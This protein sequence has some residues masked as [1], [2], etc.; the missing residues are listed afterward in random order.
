MAVQVTLVVAVA[1]NGIIGAQGG[2]P[3]H[4]PA[5]LSHFKQV[6]LGKPVLMGRLT[7]DSIGRPLP[8]RRNLVLTS[9]PEWQ[10]E[11]AQRVSSLDQALALA[12]AG[13]A[14]ELMVIG[15]AA[16]YHL[17]LPRA[18]RIYLTRVHAAPEGDTRFPDLD[19]DQWEE[20]AQRERLADER[21][22]HDLTFVVLERAR[23]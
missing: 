9:D 21:N 18:Q 10:A 3:W 16:V 6:T 14:Q 11:G 15:G 20:V 8:G 22:A 4:L 13:G 5:D 23:P 12:E 1:D 17:A 19:P 7:W 2:M